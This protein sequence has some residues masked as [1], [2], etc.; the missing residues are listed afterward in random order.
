MVLG[1]MLTLSRT[2][3]LALV[4]LLGWLA[5]KN[6]NK[7]KRYVVSLPVFLLVL[8]IVYLSNMDTINQG[9]E[10]YWTNL[11][12]RF[13]ESD[14]SVDASGLAS[15]RWYVWEAAIKAIQQNFF[16]GVGSGNL[17][18]VIDDYSSVVLPR[19]T[20]KPNIGLVAH[21]IILSIWSEMG[22]IGIAIFSAILFIQFRR[23]FILASKNRWGIAMLVALFLLM[24]F[25]ISLSWE[26][27]KIV[28]VVL[29]S[30]S[31]VWTSRHYLPAQTSYAKSS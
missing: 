20:Y 9:V 10:M 6:L 24:F 23:S 11:E 13:L 2:G 31:L 5:L 15:A 27:K 1:T 19:S 30:T 16:L 14:S 22:L 18:Y 4:L 25:G 7:L 3:L 21:N 29:G 8:G 17:P 12:S 28:Y 26:F